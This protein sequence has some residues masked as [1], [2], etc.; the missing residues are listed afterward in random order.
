MN[1]N[2]ARQKRKRR[3][4][5][6]NFWLFP[7]QSF[8]CKQQRAG[9]INWLPC[10]RQQLATV[11]TWPRGSVTD[12]FPGVRTFYDFFQLA[13]RLSTL[14]TDLWDRLRLENCT[15]FLGVACCQDTKIMFLLA[16][17]GLVK[18]YLKCFK[19]FYFTEVPHIKKQKISLWRHFI[20]Y[21]FLLKFC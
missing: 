2:G 21:T 16:G 10:E 4:Q 1:P 13:A 8:W 20:W 12:V 6:D 17:I 5:R 19:F 18:V 15:H 7:S 14:I 3:H 9:L 11:Q